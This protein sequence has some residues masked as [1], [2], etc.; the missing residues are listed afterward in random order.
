MATL[1]VRR[2]TAAAM[3]HAVVGAA[4]ALEEPLVALLGSREFYDRF[5]FKPARDFGIAAPDPS[6]G[7]HFQVRPLARYSNDLAGAF[8]YAPPF[9]DL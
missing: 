9:N 7:D 3:I 1:I 8:E 2:E 4:D 5:G 6:W